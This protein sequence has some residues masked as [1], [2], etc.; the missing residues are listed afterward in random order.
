MPDGIVFIWSPAAISA[1]VAGGFG[2]GLLLIGPFA[3]SPRYSAGLVPP[4]R[5]GILTAALGALLGLAFFVGQAV[6]SYATGDALWPRVVAR[7]GVWLI[8]AAALGVGTFIRVRIED[9]RRKARFL[10]RARYTL[11][12]APLPPPL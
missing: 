2:M 12:D 3:S 6:A 4:S 1:G 5:I 10:A 11:H 8:F 7:F 9:R